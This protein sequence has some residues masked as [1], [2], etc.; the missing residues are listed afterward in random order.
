MRLTKKQIKKY[1]DKGYLCLRNIISNEIICSGKQEVEKIIKYIPSDDV[2]KQFGCI[3]EM[4]S[5]LENGFFSSKEYRKVRANLKLQPKVSE[6]LLVILPSILKQLTKQKEIFLL[7]EQY[8]VKPPNS[9]SNFHWH[10]DS[11]YTSLPFNYISVWI[12]FEHVSEENGCLFVIPFHFSKLNMDSLMSSEFDV[13]ERNYKP[14]IKKRGLEIK[15]N[16]GDILIFSSHLWHRSPNNRSSR[17]RRVIMPQYSIN[18]LKRVDGTF[19][20]FAVKV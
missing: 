2:I 4:M 16:P 18:P 8:V 20:R 14:S 10:V 6:I 7:N 15:M 12:P 1:F 5:E 17:Y 3:I 11:N 9:K 19:E 13:Y